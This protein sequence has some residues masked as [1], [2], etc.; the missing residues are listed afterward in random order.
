MGIVKCTPFFG[1]RNLPQV[2]ICSQEIQEIMDALFNER[3]LLANVTDR[4]S[5]LPS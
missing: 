2:H 4:S 5:D 3:L 1:R